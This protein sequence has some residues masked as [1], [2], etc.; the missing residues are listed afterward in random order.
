MTTQEELESKTVTQE[1]FNSHDWCLVDGEHVYEDA[2]EYID[3]I[4][5]NTL[6]EELQDPSIQQ[7][8]IDKCSAVEVYDK[9]Y[10]HITASWLTDAI[11]DYCTEHYDFEGFGGPML[12]DVETITR[13]VNAFNEAQGQYIIDNFKGYMNLAQQ[14]SEE[15]DKILQGNEEQI[16]NILE[17]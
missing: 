14:A 4:L 10:V 7:N 5:A 9:D 11:D 12:P 1:E 16:R 2:E 8:I 13:F 3:S 17:G 6:T 15:I